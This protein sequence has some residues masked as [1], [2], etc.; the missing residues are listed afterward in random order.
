MVLLIS[1]KEIEIP[2]SFSN[3]TASSVMVTELK[4]PPS[5]SSS[6][7][8]EILLRV[9]LEQSEMLKTNSK[10]LLCV[11]DYLITTV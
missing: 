9:S 1:I 10:D 4:M 5:I 3:A 6:S 7:V 11:K 8:E 2:N